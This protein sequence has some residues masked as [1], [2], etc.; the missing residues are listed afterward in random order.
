MIY[1]LSEFQRRNLDIRGETKMFHLF[2]KNGRQMI[3]VKPI[4]EAPDRMVWYVE[5]DG[6]VTPFFKQVLKPIE[7]IDDL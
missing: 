4:G 5:Y 2:D 1:E 7:T 3:H 6:E